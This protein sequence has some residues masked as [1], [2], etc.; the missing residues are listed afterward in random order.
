MSFYLKDIKSYR[1]AF[2][3]MKLKEEKFLE[4]KDGLVSIMP[5]INE[6]TENVDVEKVFNTAFGLSIS[7]K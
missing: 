3:F 1:F 7:R 2:A 4:G 6:C 5:I